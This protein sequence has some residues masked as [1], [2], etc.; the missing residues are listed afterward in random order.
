MGANSHNTDDPHQQ[1]YEDQWNGRIDMNAPSSPA[2]RNETYGPIE[3]DVLTLCLRLCLEPAD[4]HSPEVHAV[5]DH[6]RPAWEAAAG[7]MPYDEALD[8]AARRPSLGAQDEPTTINVSF[9]THLRHDGDIVRVTITQGEA[10][11]QLT[12]EQA[13]AL[14]EQLKVQP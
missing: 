8:K 10:K 13:H 14:S 12:K 1:D 7:G 3:Y 6:Y 9:K 11:L 2:P 4:T 5:M